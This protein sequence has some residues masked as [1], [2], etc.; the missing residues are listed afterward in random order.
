MI[1]QAPDRNSI[2]LD[3]FL[4]SLTRAEAWIMASGNHNI[5]FLL[6]HLHHD[7]TL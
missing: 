6:H 1:T 4:Y 7:A 5:V 3:V 2:S